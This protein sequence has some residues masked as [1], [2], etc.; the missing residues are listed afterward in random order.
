MDVKK[1]RAGE[2]GKDIRDRHLRSLPFT[3]KET[4]TYRGEGTYPS[5]TTG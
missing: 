4:R 1:G 5:H 2:G 3:H